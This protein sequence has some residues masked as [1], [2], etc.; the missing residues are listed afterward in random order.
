MLLGMLSFSTLSANTD[1]FIRRTKIRKKQTTHYRTSVITTNITYVDDSGEVASIKVAIEV[2]DKESPLPNQKEFFCKPSGNKKKNRY[3]AVCDLTCESGICLFGGK[4]VLGNRYKLTTTMLNKEGKQVGKTK[5]ETVTVKEGGNSF[6][7]E[8]YTFD[9]ATVSGTNYRKLE[10][11]DRLI[12]PPLGKTDNSM[13]IPIIPGNG[14]TI[15]SVDVYS[16][17]EDCNGNVSTSIKPAIYN[18]K[19]KLYEAPAP[20][21][22]DSKCQ[23]STNDLVVLVNNTCLETKA[24]KVQ[25]DNVIEVKSGDISFPVKF[26][27]KEKE[28][29]GESKDS[30]DVI[31]SIKSITKTST[32]VQGQFIFGVV[33][34]LNNT[35]K[36]PSIPQVLGQI[37]N[38]D[39][40]IENISMKVSFDEKSNTYVGSALRTHDRSC[41]WKFIGVSITIK[42]SCGKASNYSDRGFKLK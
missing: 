38:C 12:F 40:K 1:A 10:A 14:T 19:T 36:E 2:A 9:R 30:C 25:V 35:K 26:Q 29:K 41:K 21:G 31:Y 27:K 20:V 24:Y 22:N 28:G 32:E 16:V 42:N 33:F 3:E 15:S 37:E 18:T 13:T 23:S 6:C 11:G 34:G 7:D 5:T 8:N 17:L 39:G 4:L